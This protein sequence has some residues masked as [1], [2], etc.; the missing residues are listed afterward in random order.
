MPLAGKGE[1]FARC[2]YQRPK[3][4]VQVLGRPLAVRVIESLGLSPQDLLVLV[5]HRSLEQEQFADLILHTFPDLQIVFHC[6][7]QRTRGA[8]ETVLHGLEVLPDAARDSP[9]LLADG[10]GL[11]DPS[12]LASFRKLPGNVIFCV[13]DE[14]DEP[15]Y[16][17]VEVDE[18]LRVTDIAEKNRLSPYACIG[19]YGFASAALLQ[20]AAL[21]TLEN[22]HPQGGEYYLSSAVRVLLQQGQE[23]RAALVHHWTCLGTPEQLQSWCR[24]QVLLSRL[25]R[26]HA[27]FDSVPD[28]PAQ[29]GEQESGYY[30]PQ[31]VPARPWHKIVFSTDAVEKSGPARK[32]GHELSWYKNLP[33]RLAPHVPMLISHRTSGST[34]LLKLDRVRGVPLCHLLVE[35]LLTEQDL[36]ALLKVLSDF[37]ASD[38]A[39]IPPI[40]CGASIYDNYSPKLADRFERIRVIPGTQ[41]CYRVLVARAQEYQA[42]GRGREALIHGDPVFTNV[43]LTTAGKVVLVDPRGHLNGQETL[44]GDANYDLA[45]IYQSLLG[46]DAILLGRDSP[47]GGAKLRTVYEKW[48][49][50]LLGTGGLDDIRW[51]TASLYLSLLPLHEARHHGAF[52]DLCRKLISSDKT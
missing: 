24:Q 50:D 21:T 9:V 48:L 3:P 27:G 18:H 40:P 15:I 7:G 49:V 34:T 29:I 47:S 16:S 17:Y 39:G 35:E 41:E 6:I 36:M 11:V 42:S 10:D 38:L 33:R 26:R 44:R 12:L 51:I 32:V 28:L 25:G 5:Y 22:S 31:T 4:L 13:H 43:L 30:L 19:M 45:K 46:Y 37:H 52:L 23:V 1:R 14:G 2:G 8:S 20:H